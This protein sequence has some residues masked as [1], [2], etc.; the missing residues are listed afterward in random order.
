VSKNT[1]ETV[2]IALVLIFWLGMLV[3]YW[4]VALVFLVFAAIAVFNLRDREQ[5]NGQ[6]QDEDH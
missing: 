3:L 2:F 4:P 1:K 6:E 5:K